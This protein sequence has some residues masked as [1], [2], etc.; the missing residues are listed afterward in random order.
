M[1]FLTHSGHFDALSKQETEHNSSKMP[2]GFRIQSMMSIYTIRTEEV[3][4]TFYKNGMKHQTLLGFGGNT[5]FFSK[6]LSIFFL[7][8]VLHRQL[9]SLGPNDDCL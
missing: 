9:F 4:L 5:V 1:I 7:K 8:S 3:S 2:A 6:K